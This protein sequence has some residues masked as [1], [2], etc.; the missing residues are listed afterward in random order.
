MAP[1]ILLR[2]VGGNGWAMGG[3]KWEGDSPWG[4]GCSKNVL[5]CRK[6]VSVHGGKG[7]MQNPSQTK[8]QSKTASK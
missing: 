6:K 2:V 4:G 1:A 5:H 8:T 3:Q 7:P